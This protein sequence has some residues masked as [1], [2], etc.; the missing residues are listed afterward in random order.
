MS[1]LESCGSPAGRHGPAGQEGSVE[2]ANI[3]WPSVH[4]GKGHFRQ[5]KQQEQ[6]L[7]EA[8]TEGW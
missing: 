6:R 5:R 1:A 3:K 8:Y 7:N 2:G 4:G